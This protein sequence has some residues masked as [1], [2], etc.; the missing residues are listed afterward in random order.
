MSDD[1]LDDIKSVLEDIKSLLLIANQ[2]KLEEIKRALLKP[3]SVESQ[4]Y[5]LCDGENSIQDISTK[6]QK[7][8]DYTSAVISNLRKKKLVRTLE[9]TDRKVIVQTF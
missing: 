9:R 6:I 5:E 7:T 2:D 3:G 8:T 1:K 4:V